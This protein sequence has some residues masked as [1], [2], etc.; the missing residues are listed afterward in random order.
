MFTIPNTGTAFNDDQ[1]KVD[2]VDLQILA[3][4]VAQTGVVG[5][6]CAVT[7]SSGLIFAVAAGTNGVQGAR[8][9]VS[10]TSKTL[11]AGDATNPRYDLI[12]VD[13]AGAV[14]VVAGTPATNPVFPTTGLFDADGLLQKTVLKAIY[15][16]ATATVLS[17]AH[18][19]DKR[20]PLDDDLSNV[21]ALSTTTFG[22]SVLVAANA[23]ALATLAGLDQ[24][25]NTSDANKPVSTAQQTALDLKINLTQKGAASGVA[26]LD[27]SGLIDDSYIPSGI[28]RDAE[29]TAA[30]A[31]AVSALVG[32]APGSLDTLVELAAA[33][34]NDAALSATLTTL[35]G[36]KVAKSLY[37]AQTILVAT[38][39]DT[40]APLTVNVDTLVGR[41]T[42]G[43]IAS[44]SASQV[45]SMLS[46]VVGTNIQAWDGDLDTLAGLTATT[47]NFIVSVAGAWAS[48][49]PAQVKTTLSL[50]NVDNVAD[51]SKPV[52]TAQGVA[53][54]LRLLASANLSDV[55]SAPTSRYNLHDQVGA[56]C[57]VVAIA[58]VASKSGTTTIDGVALV[59][60]DYVL[61][62]AQ[63]AGAENGPWIIAA[64]AWTRP[65]DYPATGTVISRIYEVQAGTAYTGTLWMSTN[66]A[67]VTI[68]TTVTTWVC[69]N[70]PTGVTAGT[71]GDTSHIPVPTV[72][73]Q[74]RITGVT[75]V[76]PTTRPPPIAKIL[77]RQQLR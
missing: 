56:A 71:Y 16:P 65:L 54:A 53:I 73:A 40:P 13:N 1:S 37:D 39:D 68:D 52:S 75:L 51:A 57:K 18:G 25:T 29:V 64:G 49:T 20:I 61:L 26:P 15:V 41:L 66:F 72:N 17:D 5:H 35:I 77:A 50:D 8:S 27:G 34:G 2:A 38:T 11:S 48:R 19:T 22:R 10:S 60:G 46:L 31:A 74:G 7:W 63:S 58:N 12:V 76:T 30:V 43:N 21:A 70:G 4:G 44:L 32:A 23:A 3:N 42:G 67:A 14:T 9:A 45:R 36:T 28:A 59:A 6:G 33:L 55:A 24:V 62:T 47:N 69:I